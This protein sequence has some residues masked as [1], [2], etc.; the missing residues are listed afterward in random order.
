MHDPVYAYVVAILML[1][2][3]GFCALALFRMIDHFDPPEAREAP[4]KRHEAVI[5]ASV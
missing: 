3:C 1:L 4:E 5:P 2:V